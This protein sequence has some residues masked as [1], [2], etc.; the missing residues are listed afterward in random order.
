MI[1]YRLLTAALL[2]LVLFACNHKSSSDMT[3][4]NKVVDASAVQQTDGALT[5]TGFNF[6]SLPPPPGND[7]RKQDPTPDK[8]T[9]PA[10]TDWEKKIIKN[11]D[12]VLEVSDYKKYNELVHTAARQWGGYIAQEEQRESAYKVE[13]TVTI[14]VPVDQ[15]DKAVNGFALAE[16]KVLSKKITSQD[17][18]GEVIDTRSRMEAKRQVRLRYLDLLKQARNMEEILQVQNVINEI[19][20][21]IESAAGR[22]N[23]LRYQPTPFQGSLPAYPFSSGLNGPA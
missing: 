22:V 9:K 1:F 18:T 19:Q 6:D 14:K 3:D 16:E 8:I 2:P 13:N 17:V 10:Y 7:N 20:V 12:L 15:F 5:E 23:S 4:L 11:A 21:E